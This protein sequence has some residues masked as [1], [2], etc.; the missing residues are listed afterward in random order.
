M[1]A[2]GNSR[3]S[4]RSLRL[5]STVFDCTGRWN[6]CYRH[7][8]RSC[9]GLRS[10]AES[11]H[12]ELAIHH[13]RSQITIELAKKRQPAVVLL[14]LAYR[15]RKLTDRQELRG[16]RQNRTLNITI[17][18][19]TE[20]TMIISAAGI[21]REYW[22]YRT[23]HHEISENML[24]ISARVASSRAVS[25]SLRRSEGTVEHYRRTFSVIEACIHNRCHD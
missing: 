16:V 4:M 25:E 3:L 11:T 24:F 15:A 8:I 22:A 14:R 2:P 6:G 1:S 18:A 7:W 21:E 5:P 13:L 19:K 12:D 10:K 23:R 9:Q 20:S 17:V